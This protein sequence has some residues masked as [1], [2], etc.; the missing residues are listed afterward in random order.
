MDEIVA[1]LSSHIDDDRR[2]Q[3]VQERPFFP[4]E[5]VDAEVGSPM[6]LSMPAAVSTMRGGEYPDDIRE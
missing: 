1:D 6:E 5:S 2:G 3:C 4:N